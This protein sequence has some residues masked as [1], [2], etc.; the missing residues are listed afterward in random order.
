MRPFWITS[1]LM[2]GLCL[3][4]AAAQK[5]PFTF[6]AMTQVK[7]V[8]DPQLSPDGRLVAFTV[9]VVEMEKNGSNRQIWIVPASGGSPRQITTEGQNSRPR[10]SPDSRRLSFLSSRSGSQQIWTMN[11]D[12]TDARQVTRLATEADGHIWSPDGANFV[13]SSEVYPDCPDEACNE[14]RL[15]QE[16]QSKVKARVYTSLLYRHWSQWQGKRRKHVMMVPAGGGLVKDLTPGFIFDVPPFSLGGGEDYAVSPDGKEVAYVAKLDENQ[17]TSTN[18]EIF[19]VPV[20]G[21][22]PKQVS[23]SEGA[24]NGPAYSPDGK[25]LAWRMQ[26]TGG[27]ES[28]RWRLVLYNRETGSM[29]TLTETIDRNVDSFTWHPDSTRIAYVLEDRGRHPAHIISINGGGARAI[30][31][32]SSSVGDL[33]FTPDGRT[34]IYTEQSG[35]SPVEIFRAVSGEGAPVPLTRVNDA[36][37]SRYELTRYEEFTV[38]G[39]EGAQVHGFMVKPPAFNPEKRYPALMLIHGGPQG[40]WGESFSYRWNPQVF[41]AAGFVVVMPNPRGSTGYG[42]RFTDE[43]NA[44]WGGRV[45]EDLMSVADYTASLPYVD[46]RRMA[47]AG[48]SYGGYMVN[49]ILGHTDRFR[50]LVS[51]A[52][53]Y[54][55]RSMGG[56]TEELWFTRWEFKGYPWETPEIHERWSPSVHAARFSTPTLVI[57][58]ELDFRVPYGQGLQL[59]T[60]LQANGVPSKLLMY[61]D[62]GH[63]ILKPQ[64]SR[65]WHEQFIEWITEWT[66]E[67]ADGN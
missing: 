48:G 44:D 66:R 17:A 19:V 38:A 6:D 42:Q 28:D 52:G 46:G 39:A 57:H 59:F 65:L 22:E 8:S 16:K 67:R 45:Y 5:Q 36:L 37:L 12:G 11:P 26:Q 18:S 15:E 31:R 56:E 53:V 60:A 29:Q 49:W 9:S 33:Q 63:W 34:L 20:E 54:D 32:G 62:E 55:L 4:P 10:W 51:H 43:I 2:A 47:A 64:N 61:P 23:T 1:F 41:A 24:D 58:G 13:F 27:Y 7:R 30:T 25:W 50:A 3:T 40:A 21:G 35:S 14:R